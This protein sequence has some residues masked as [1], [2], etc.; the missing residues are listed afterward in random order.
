M[1]AVTQHECPYVT[2]PSQVMT[3]H[4]VSSEKVMWHVAK[5]SRLITV[6]T[7]VQRTWISTWKLAAS[8]YELLEEYVCLL[9]GS[10]KRKVNDV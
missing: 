8:A 2:I 9:Y 7:R 1:H 10:R 5:W 3:T 6:F 4:Q